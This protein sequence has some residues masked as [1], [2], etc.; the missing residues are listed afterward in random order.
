M[1][2]AGHCA[3]VLT[4]L[5]ILLRSSSA[6]DDVAVTISTCASI[7]DSSS[8]ALRS[9]SSCGAGD[10]C[11]LTIKVAGL[12]GGGLYTVSVELSAEVGAS[13]SR[14][15]AESIEWQPIFQG[16]RRVDLDAAA[17]ALREH[18]MLID[19]ATESEHPSVTKMALPRH[20]N[21]T[22]SYPQA[23]RRDGTRLV[24]RE[25]ERQVVEVD[26]DLPPIDT[27]DFL[28]VQ[29][30]R[31]GDA[32]PF[33]QEAFPMVEPNAVLDVGAEAAGRE[34][35][36]GSRC[37]LTR[38]D[39]PL[40]G[41]GE[42]VGEGEEAACPLVHVVYVKGEYIDVAVN[43]VQRAYPSLSPDLSYLYLYQYG[44][45]TCISVNTISISVADL[46]S[47]ASLAASINRDRERHTHR[48]CTHMRKH[49]HIHT[50]ITR[51]W[52]CAGSVCVIFS[53]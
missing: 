51:S 25:G 17:V 18:G 38:P 52:R 39:T 11:A 44:G 28:A 33:V 27:Q 1:G 37:S 29:I 35:S 7:P 40:A 20:D 31:V 48:P 36:T 53:F 45:P 2:N 24:A 50:H 12:E 22:F 42:E 41:I 30:T 10:A 46:P 16:H 19:T 8:A 15:R 3:R 9:C 14:A 47:P 5:L 49:M 6:D 34:A 26:F 13:D 43:S 23:S 21:D 4:T 32:G